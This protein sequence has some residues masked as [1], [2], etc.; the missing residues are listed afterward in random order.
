MCNMHMRFICTVHPDK[1]K[2]RTPYY[3]LLIHAL[4]SF[5]LTHS[6]PSRFCS[7]PRR[8][9]SIYAAVSVPLRLPPAAAPLSACHMLGYTSEPAF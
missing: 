9:V 3:G 6:L 4:R 8:H 1:T 2:R 7:S 5:A